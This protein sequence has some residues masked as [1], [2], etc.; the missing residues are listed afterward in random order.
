MDP[1]FGRRVWAPALPRLERL[2]EG[3]LGAVL[4]RFRI[5]KD[6]RQGSV[7]AWVRAAVEAIE[8]LSRA[9][10]VRLLPPIRQ[11]WHVG[12]NGTG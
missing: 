9:R 5:A 10:L 1:G 2:D 6:H 4:G 8:V 3:V 12:Y 11:R 7:D